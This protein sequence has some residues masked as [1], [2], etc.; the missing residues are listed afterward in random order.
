MCLNY[1]NNN[2]FRWCYC[3][4]Y[5]GPAGVPDGC[6]F[7]RAGYMS[8]HL[9]APT[10]QHTRGTWESKQTVTETK[11]LSYLFLWRAAEQEEKP[12]TSLVA[13]RL[14]IRLP[15]Q[16][17]WVWSLVWEDPTCHEATEPVCRSPSPRALGS[18]LCN[19]RS[20]R[21]E[22]PTHRN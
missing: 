15:M 12:C 18:V 3:F 22:K 14:R 13:Q 16:G 9:Y 11:M 21:S 2:Y 10:A 8:H 20:H 1:N 7:P 5:F 17:T 6:Q 19:K 4:R